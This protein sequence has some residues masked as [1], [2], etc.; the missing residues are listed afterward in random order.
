VSIK[1][2]KLLD[3]ILKLRGNYEVV[4]DINALK[5]K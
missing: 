1:Y 2:N 5:S 4:M 3:V